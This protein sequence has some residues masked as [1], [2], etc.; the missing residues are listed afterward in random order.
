MKIFLILLCCIVGAVGNEAVFAI[1][2]TNADSVT[3]AKSFSVFSAD[4]AECR[5]EDSGGNVCTYSENAIFGDKGAKLMAPTIVV[6]RGVDGQIAKVVAIGRAAAKAIYSSVENTNSEVAKKN[7]NVE[8]N[9]SN[10]QNKKVNANA[11]NIVI[12][13]S[14]RLA[15]LDGNAVVVQQRDII[16]GQHLE[17]DLEK[18]TVLSKPKKDQGPATVFL[19]PS[20]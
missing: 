1:N 18:K 10:I 13:P 19:H 14:K 7:R 2:G 17:Y 6:Y 8:G 16:T 20:E 11:D 9:Q 5:Q 12:Y 15:I 3:G 4:S